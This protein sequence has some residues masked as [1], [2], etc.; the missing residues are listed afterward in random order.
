MIYPKDVLKLFKV[1][2]FPCSTTHR[3]HRSNTTMLTWPITVE[4]E[5]GRISKV[6]KSNPLQRYRVA[7]PKP[8][9]TNAPPASSSV[10]EILQLPWP[11]FFIVPLFLQWGSFHWETKSSLPFLFLVFL[12]RT[13]ISAA[14]S[15]L[16]CYCCYPL[17]RVGRK[18]LALQIPLA[19]GT[20]ASA[21]WGSSRVGAV[22]WLPPPFCCMIHDLSAQG[23]LGSRA[24]E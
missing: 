21:D 6:I 23:L 5:L 12:C 22:A 14:S 16:V 13:H 8:S 9:Q 4:S 11:A 18:G 10:K 1:D 19:S 20:C 3:E 17:C 2:F 15:L 7:V 24:Q